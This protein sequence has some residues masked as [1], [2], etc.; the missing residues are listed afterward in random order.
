MF[1]FRRRPFNTEKPV[2]AEENLTGFD[3]RYVIPTGVPVDGFS[4]P[5]Q[6]QPQS[7]GQTYAPQSAPAYDRSMAEPERPMV[8]ALREHPDMYVYEYSD[9]FE[10]YRRTPYGMERC[11]TEYRNRR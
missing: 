11:N 9:R 3:E 2:D 4:Q 6:P 5:Q 7:G 8:F 1:P 10:Y